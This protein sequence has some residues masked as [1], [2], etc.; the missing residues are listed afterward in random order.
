MIYKVTFGF[1]GNGQGWSETHAMKNSS[2]L[3]KVALAAAVAVAEKRVTF[4][5]REFSINIVR[6]SAYSDD[7]G[8]M[9]KRGIAPSDIGWAN[10]VQTA[11]AAAEPAVVALKVTG[12]TNATLSAG[13]PANTNRTFCGAPP[14]A[15]VDN[16]GVV[17]QG[18]AGLGAAFT[19]WS[20][21]LIA[22][23]FGWL[24]SARTSDTEI[25]TITQLGNGK[26]EFT[27]LAPPNPAPTLLKIYMV[28][29]R[30]VN[31]GR[32]PLNGQLIC[33]YSAA[34]TFV[35]Q[36][37]IGLALAQTGGSIRIYNPIQPFAQYAELSLAGHTAKHKRGRPFGASP[38]RAP[39]RIRG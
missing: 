20:N 37:V 26:V 18:K 38:G 15:A 17:D 39:K 21:L 27:T 24:I 34:S 3:P 10:P 29:V 8:T 25:A 6:V 11:I 28:R 33:R 32:S 19:Q 36:E 35:T 13:F 2:E 16:A 9:R 23:S 30:G 12:F 7:A 5:G 1:T 14:D 22:N 31:D 4:L